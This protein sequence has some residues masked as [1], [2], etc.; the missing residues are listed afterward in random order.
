MDI[1]K[2]LKKYGYIGILSYKEELFPMMHFFV[3]GIYFQ[4]EKYYCAISAPLYKT[5][6]VLIITQDEYQKILSSKYREKFNLV[7]EKDPLS[8]TVK[9]QYGMKKIL[10]SDFDP[11]RYIL[12]VGYPDFPPCPYGESFR[13]LGYDTK[14]KVYVRLAPKLLKDKRLQTEVYKE[15]E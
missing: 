9:R 13:M 15:Q 10:K 5:K 12:R 4:N 14:D 6:G 3:D 7:I 11:N 8:I 2:E 1:V